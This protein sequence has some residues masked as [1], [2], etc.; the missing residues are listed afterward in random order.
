M[1]PGGICSIISLLSTNQVVFSLQYIYF[2]HL[3]IF[4]A[5]INN[6]SNSFHS[7]CFPIPIANVYHTIHF[8]FIPPITLCATP[9]IVR[10]F[11]FSLPMLVISH[12]SLLKT[13]YTRVKLPIRRRHLRRSCTP[14]VIY[15][16]FLIL[17]SL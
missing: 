7:I 16:D 1:F 15:P 9:E 10:D 14:R 5:K 8:L 17:V 6:Y 3:K 2:F 4:I 13:E 11:D 12:R